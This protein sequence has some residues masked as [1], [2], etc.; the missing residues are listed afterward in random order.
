M[1]DKNKLVQRVSLAL[2]EDDSH[3]LGSQDNLWQ[4][5][6]LL[7]DSLQRE[8]LQDLGDDHL[9]LVL[10]EL[11]ADAAKSTKEIG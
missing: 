10:G 7:V 11:L 8:L 6:D 9:L 3:S 5:L 4:G 2:L 1:A